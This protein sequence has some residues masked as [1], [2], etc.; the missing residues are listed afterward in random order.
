[1]TIRIEAVQCWRGTINKVDNYDAEIAIQIGEEKK[2]YLLSAN[3][4]K[5]AAKNISNLKEQK[6]L[7]K[8]IE[9][10]KQET[11]ELWPANE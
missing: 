8:I 3:K 2:Q 6:I 1:M 4:T 5:E 10:I 9:V 11:M 7:T